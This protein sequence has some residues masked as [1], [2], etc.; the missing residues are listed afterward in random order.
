MRVAEVAVERQSD[1]VVAFGIG[2]DEVNG[3]AEW[4][5]DVLPSR[6]TRACP[7]AACWRNRWAVLRLG[8]RGTRCPAYRSRIRAAEDAE[9]MRRLRVDDIPLE[10]CITSNVRHQAPCRP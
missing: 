5:R 10:V 3:P 7:G 4:F 6:P 8:V 2:G 9:L 1:G